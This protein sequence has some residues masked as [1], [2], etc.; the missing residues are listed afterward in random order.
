MSNPL[1]RQVGGNHYKDFT[2]QP[3]EVCKAA[4]NAYD[5]CIASAFKYLCRYPF[6]GKWNEDLEKAKHYI[7]MSDYVVNTNTSERVNLLR[8]VE[9]FNTVNKKLS[10]GQRSLL[11]VIARSLLI[12]DGKDVLCEFIL[13]AKIPD[14]NDQCGEAVKKNHSTVLSNR[15][16]ESTI[17]PRITSYTSDV[18]DGHVICVAEFDNKVRIVETVDIRGQEKVDLVNTKKNLLDSIINSA[19]TIFVDHI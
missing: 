4:A 6:K 7:E 16:G 9:D 17:F 18:V 15:C 1:D 14:L 2:M 8:V 3:I 19:K 11:Y 5:Y 13:S 10:D 12:D